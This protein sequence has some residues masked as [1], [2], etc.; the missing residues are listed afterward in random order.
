MV[1][2]TETQ[3]VADDRL[4]RLL[5]VRDDVRSGQH[6]AAELRLVDALLHL[7]N[8]VPT[9]DLVGYVN[10]LPLVV[11]PAHLPESQKDSELGGEVLLDEGRVDRAVPVRSRA[12][13]VDDGQRHPE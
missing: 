6:G 4:A 12:P 5:R 3:A 10:R 7:A 1:Y 9:L 11:R 8:D 2:R 13:E